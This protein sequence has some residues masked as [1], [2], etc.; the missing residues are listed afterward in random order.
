MEL[1]A[2]DMITAIETLNKTYTEEIDIVSIYK[3]L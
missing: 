3:H 2:R 1:I